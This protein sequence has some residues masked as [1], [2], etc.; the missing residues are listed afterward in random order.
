[1]IAIFGL[2]QLSFLWVLRHE[3]TAQRHQQHE[4]LQAILYEMP[5]GVSSGHLEK[6]KRIKSLLCEYRMCKYVYRPADAYHLAFAADIQHQISD[7]QSDKVSNKTLHGIEKQVANFPDNIGS[8]SVTKCAEI[9]AVATALW[10]LCTRTRRN[11]QNVDDH[12]V[13]NHILFNDTVLLAK[14]FAFLLLDCTRYHDQRNTSD[15]ARLMKVALR[16]AK[17]CLSK[18]H[19]RKNIGEISLTLNFIDNQRYDVAVKVME[20][21]AVYESILKKSDKQVSPEDREIYVQMI[22]EYF[23]LRTSLVS[24]SLHT[25]VPF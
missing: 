4:E 22:S 16:T 11:I 10:N 15:V 2:A 17:T 24:T 9:D 3:Q 20:K 19:T 8:L 23:V 14:G 6:G 13:E 1:M 18:T 12:G 21:A 7:L 25:S 5:P